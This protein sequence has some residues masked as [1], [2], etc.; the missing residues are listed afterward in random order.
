MKIKPF[1][2]NGIAILLLL[3]FLFVFYQMFQGVTP[4]VTTTESFNETLW[5]TWA[6]SI[7]IISFILFAGGL[8]ILV[9]VGGGWRWE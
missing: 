5:S 1:L 3:G 2:T 7:L 9:L 8:G 4:P 6:A